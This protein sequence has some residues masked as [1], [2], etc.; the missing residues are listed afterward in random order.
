MPA[1]DEAREDYLTAL[2][3]LG[4]GGAAVT[5]NAL[6]AR[7]GVAPASATGMLKALARQGLV[8]HQLYR[9]AQLSQRGR[10]RALGIVRRHRLVETFLVSVLG[11]P[12]DRV[13][14]EA[15]RLEHALS[16]EVVERL[17][18]WLGRP[19]LDPHGSPIPRAGTP[20]STKRKRDGVA[21]RR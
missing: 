17:D 5:T 16:D 12:P 3:R 21:P 9:G 4:E 7:L 14:A 2:L 6:A 11:L 1:S 19:A 13:H 20:A 18:H 10:T 8:E 15:H